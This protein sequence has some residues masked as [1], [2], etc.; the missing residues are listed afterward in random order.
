[1]QLL[2]HRKSSFC[3]KQYLLN[4]LVYKVFHSKIC[5]AHI[6]KV[7]QLLAYIVNMFSS[8]LFLKPL[9]F[10]ITCCPTK[11]NFLSIEIYEMQTTLET[12]LILFKLQNMYKTI[13]LILTIELVNFY[14]DTS[15]NPLNVL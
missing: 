11:N 9:N 10:N 2:R 13:D 8:K 3:T 6:L 5:C 12:K 14:N 4:N 1:M 7:W 15:P